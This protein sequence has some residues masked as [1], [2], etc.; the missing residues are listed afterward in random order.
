MYQQSRPGNLVEDVRALFMAGSAVGLSDRDLLE[1]FL[2]SGREFGEDAFTALVERHGP[3]V[4]RVCKQALR[5]SHAA[6]DAFQATFLV[7]ARQARSIRQ[8]DSVESWL[9]GVAIRAAGRIRVLEA[10]R[11]RYERHV[12]RLC[13]QDEASASDSH[14]PWT[15]LHAEIALLPE[16]YRVPV[17]LCY[18]EGLTHDQ[19]ALRLGWPIGTVKTRLSRA[20]ER[21]RWRLEGRGCSSA[22][23]IPSE[24]LRPPDAAPISRILLD[25]TT[26]AAVRFV[27]G[28]GPGESLS[29][30]VLAISQGVL[31]TMLIKSLRIAAIMVFGVAALGLGAFV[32]ARQI[33][34]ERQAESQPLP[35]ARGRF[36]GARS[37]PLERFDRVR[38][39]DNRTGPRTPRLPH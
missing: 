32:V 20:R 14:E 2:H 31:K 39:R 27:S 38:S 29:V 35:P 36:D 10:R 13:G 11:R 23:L 28:A 37:T 9:F 22:T 26:Q 4:L 8:R 17:V 1:R 16:K 12:A 6:E 7:L 15:E 33:P 19:A 3:M 21:L 25:T 30:A 34:G 18:F 24:Y 5:D